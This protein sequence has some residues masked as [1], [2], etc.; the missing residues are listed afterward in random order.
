MKT[1]LVATA[2]FAALVMVA[3]IGK[4]HANA[5]FAPC[6]GKVVTIAGQHFDMDVDSLRRCATPADLRGS[7]PADPR[8]YARR[9]RANYR[10][11]VEN[12]WCK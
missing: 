1:L 11:C 10:W 3:P 6:E 8:A 7:S 2:A 4:A 12:G 9:Q 5:T